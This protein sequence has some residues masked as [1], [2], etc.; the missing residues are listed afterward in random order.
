MS[1]RK[2]ATR[3]WSGITRIRRPKS[4]MSITTTETH[5]AGMW[6]SIRIGRHP[7]GGIIVPGAGLIITIHGTGGIPGF[8]GM[9]TGVT[10]RIMVG[11]TAGITEDTTIRTGPITRI[12]ILPRLPSGGRS[13]AE[14]L[15]VAMVMHPR[16]WLR[17]IPGA[18]P[19][20]HLAMV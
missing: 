7:I 1:S 14:W 10:V 3:T 4:S 17:V 19:R 13:T 5:T 2:K 18:L 9:A 15:L 20:I 6:D 16:L 11:I 12:G 8:T